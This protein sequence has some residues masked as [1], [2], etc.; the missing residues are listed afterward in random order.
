MIPLM[1][2]NGFLGS[3]KTTLLRRIVE[4][5]SARRYVYLINEFSP[6][7]IDSQVLQVDED[8]LVSIAGGSQITAGAEEA[9]VAVVETTATMEEVRTTAETTNRKSSNVAPD[10][11]T[12]AGGGG[13]GQIRHGE[14]L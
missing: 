13:K 11:P 6:T 1:L 10:R 8:C 5:N 3:G 2:V 12:G 9:S 14:A 4:R 7:D